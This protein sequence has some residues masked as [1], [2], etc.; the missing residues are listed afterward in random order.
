[1]R[2]WP[3]MSV[4]V[5]PLPAR[6]GS[7]VV[8]FL[9]FAGLSCWSGGRCASDEGRNDEVP[10]GER[11]DHDRGAEEQGPDAEHALRGTVVNVRAV[12]EGGADGGEDAQAQD[13]QAVDGAELYGRGEVHLVARGQVVAEP[14]GAEPAGQGADEDRRD[15]AGRVVLVEHVLE[16]VDATLE[17]LNSV[18]VDA[19]DP[20]DEACDEKDGPDQDETHSDHAYFLFPWMGDTAANTRATYTYCNIST[21]LLLLKVHTSHEVYIYYNTYASKNQYI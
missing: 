13:D 8:L 1:M 17:A 4:L 19:E 9:R 14:G 15:S 7:S 21:K 10:E 20:H 6:G 3:T 2:Q 18:L 12:L 16:A 5:R 11:F